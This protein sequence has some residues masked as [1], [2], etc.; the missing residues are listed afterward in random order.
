[1]VCHFARW[2]GIP[3]GAEMVEQNWTSGASVAAGRWVGQSVMEAGVLGAA[4]C[5][6]PGVHRNAVG[7]GD[8]GRVSLVCWSQVSVKRRINY[9]WSCW[10]K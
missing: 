5:K 9:V 1:M 7:R 10:A 4:V 2:R 6:R 8:S 3:G